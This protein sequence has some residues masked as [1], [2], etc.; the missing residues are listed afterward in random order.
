VSWGAVLAL[1]AGA[2]LLKAAG[3]LL[4]D[5]VP[6]ERADRWSL[7]LLAV[8]VLAGLIVV[9]TLDGGRELVLD[10]RTPAVLAGALLLWRGAPLLVVALGAGATAAG[11][12]LLGMA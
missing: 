6:P 2:Y 8:P 12:R 10:A 9:Q 4:A 3:L 7:E 1:S 5:R 11:L